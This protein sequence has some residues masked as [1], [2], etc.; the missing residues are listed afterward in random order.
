VNTSD[1]S[2]TALPAG[3]AAKAEGGPG[4]PAAA[5]LR[6]EAPARPSGWTGGRITALVIGALLALVS[7]GLLGSGGTA[8]WVDRTQRDGAGYVTTHVRKFST[9]GS[10]LST[11]RIDL[12]SAGIGWLYSA[13]LLDKV[14]IRVTPAPPG[15][16]WI[17]HVDGGQRCT[18]R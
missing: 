8:L 16:V 12:G 18:A 13:T 5:S 1:I 7:L 2:S 9:A 17:S 3:E 11:E 14:R 10:A 6:P 15:S 4:G